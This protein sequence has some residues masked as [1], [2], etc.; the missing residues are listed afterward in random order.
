MQKIANQDWLKLSLLMTIALTS[1]CQISQS[2]N[3]SLTR[4]RCEADS[5]FAFIPEGEFIQGSDRTE[6]DFAYNISAKAN[7]PTE[8]EIEQAEQKLRQTGWF[9]RESDRATASTPNYCISRN[10]V[11]NQEY[12]EFVR[13]TN[14]RSPGITAAEYQQQGFLVHPYSKVEEFLW[15]AGTYPQDT[16]KHP[17][18][19]VSYD[20]ALAYA[21]WKESQTGVKYRLPTDLEWE[22]AARGESG[23]YFPWGND[24]QA[25]ATNFG[26]SG[27][28]YT[29][30]IASY[31]QSKS[32]YGVE[33]MAGNVFEY[34]STLEQQDSLAVMK[35]CSWDDS[36]GFCR[37]AYQHTRPVD[38]RHILFGF[39]LIKTE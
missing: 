29:S 17:V 14:H 4:D 24:W 37:A 12:Q 34:T 23:N 28:N 26:G 18:V 5:N 10:L 36:P 30:A 9:D 11:T 20:D 7:S 27:I 2:A 38:S 32:V 22:K 6:R 19:L 13:A 15:Q 25:E 16:A 33:D 39:R 31:P 3:S 21:D 35:G 1:G 8:A